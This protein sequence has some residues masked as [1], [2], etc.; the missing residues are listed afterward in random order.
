GQRK[1]QQ[2]PRRRVRR[3]SAGA[4]SSATFRVVGNPDH[5]RR[6]GDGK[7]DDDKAQANPGQQ[8]ERGESYYL[9]VHLSPLRY[10]PKLAYNPR[11]TMSGT[12]AQ[13]AVP[14]TE[15]IHCTSRVNVIPASTCGARP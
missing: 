5:N 7:H 12:M 10:T 11:A 1:R 4:Q 9:P 8:I 3:E 2:L 15:K 14:T 6:S 13:T